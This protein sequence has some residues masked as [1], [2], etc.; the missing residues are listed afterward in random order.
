MACSPPRGTPPHNLNPLADEFIPFGLLLPPYDDLDRDLDEPDHDLLEWNASEEERIDDMVSE[1]SVWLNFKNSDDTA[2][3]HDPCPCHS[4]PRGSCPEIKDYHVNRIR[5]GLEQFGITPNMDSL[6]EPL[7]FPSFPLANWEW[8]LRGYFDAREILDGLRFGWDVSFSQY[9]TPRDAKWNLQGA[10]LFEKDV[11]AYIDQE[12]KFGALVGPFDEADL[13]FKTFCSPLNTVPKKN[14]AT[15]RTV[16]DC[17]QC[18]KGVNAFIDAHLHRGKY[19]KLSL[20]NSQSIITRI[21]RARQRYPGQ[22]I[23]IFKLDF[24][25]W[26]RWFVLDPVATIFFAIR[27]RGRIFIDTALSF[28]NRAAA[29]AAQRVIWAVVHMFRTRVPPFPGSFNS[30]IDCACS[31]HCQCGE[32]DAEGYIDDFIGFVPQCLAQV[33]FDA[34]VQLTQFLGLR[35]SETPGHVSPPSASC[36]C[37]GILY[38]TDNNTMCLPQDKVR[39]ISA[40]LLDWSNKTRATD[41]ELAVLCGK[42]LYCCNVIFAGRLFL[43]RCLATKRFASR[44]PEATYLTQD[45]YDDI[46]WWIDAIKLRNGVSFLV[47]DAELHV[48][49]DASSNAWH[50]GKPG[51]GGFNHASNQYFSCTVPD[52]MADWCI[53]NLELLAHVVAFHL[54]AAEWKNSVVMVHTDNQACYWLLTKGRSRD[55]L[56]LRM[57]RW[58]AM[59]QITKEFR[60]QSAWIPTSENTLA[61]SLSRYG[62]QEHRDNFDAYRKAAA[63]TPIRCHVVPEHFAFNL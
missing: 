9:P 5:R 27:W 55:D 1:Q 26:Y 51:L 59:Q 20:P 46:K 61:D 32:N 10:S 8:A 13:P 12:L 17:T 39:D 54:W 42:L 41:H 49:L 50:E 34:A 60:S 40:L 52:E 28:G 15:R 35:L 2:K 47:P 21:Q 57:S 43:N 36:E 30:G 45:F 63:K 7:K 14:S 25:R 22:R 23:L 37:L 48:S 18:D 3:P 24:A 19:W 58:L 4:L 6:R 44:L 29:L 38:D 53:A 62:E 16:V 31:D 33:Q 56:R 11:Q